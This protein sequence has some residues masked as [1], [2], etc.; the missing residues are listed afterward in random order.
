MEKNPD[1]ESIRYGFFE[2]LADSLDAEH[3]S[4]Y[5]NTDIIREAISNARYNPIVSS[6]IPEIDA[7]FGNTMPV[8]SYVRSH[9]KI[10]RNDPCPCGSGIKLKKCCFIVL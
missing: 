5:Y 2:L 7:L 6:G 10:G 4:D 3:V 1:S 9:P 8:Q